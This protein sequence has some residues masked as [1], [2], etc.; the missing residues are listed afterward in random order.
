MT[1]IF[2]CLRKYLN[3]HLT[4]VCPHQKIQVGIVLIAATFIKRQENIRM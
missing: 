3:G 2:K 1:L 4:Y